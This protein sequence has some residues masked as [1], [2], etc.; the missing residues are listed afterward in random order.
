MRKL[1]DNE[2][3]VINDIIYKI[4]SIES[5]NQMHKDVLQLL[6]HL[7]QYDSAWV[8]LRDSK[9]NLSHPTYINYSTEVANEYIESGYK[10]DYA[11]G[12]MHS[13]KCLVF[14]DTDLLS[15]EEREKTEYYKLYY[16]RIGMHYGIQMMLAHNNTFLGEIGL[17]RKRE[18]GDFSEKDI[19]ILEMLKEH[20][21]FRLHKESIKPSTYSNSTQHASTTFEKEY[22][23]SKRE[24]EVLELI[25]KGESTEQIS[26]SLF[27]SNNTV[28]KH[29]LNL[30]RK[31][32]VNSRLQL[33]NLIHSAVRV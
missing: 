11:S 31:F 4:N 23:L 12:I 32:N 13:S 17:L 6:G 26:N 1:N 18:N 29:S 25:L 22:N 5:I 7:I 10:I 8:L 33:V 9:G 19:F 2:W 30:Y 27:I 20:W 3:I 15:S 28:K 21:A 24:L 14:R 16:K